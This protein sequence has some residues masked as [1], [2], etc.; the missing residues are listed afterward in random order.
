[1]ESVATNGTWRVH[2]GVISIMGITLA[3]AMSMAP[4]TRDLSVVELCAG[5]ASVV[6]VA[7][8]QNYKAVAC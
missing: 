6:G 2:Y 8:L 4:T 3:V 5:V 1:M 7:N